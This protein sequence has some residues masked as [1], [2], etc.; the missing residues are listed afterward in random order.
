MT[1]EDPACPTCSGPTE[2]N[3]YAVAAIWTKGIASYGD[4]K[5]EN[6]HKQQRDGGH[7]TMETDETGKV[8]KTFISTQQQNRDYC[9]RNGLINPNDIPSNISIAKDGKSFEKNN[10]SE[11]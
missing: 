9:R 6:F 2:R 11:V 4:Q 7:W 10:I 1:A 8:S 5:S 3:Y